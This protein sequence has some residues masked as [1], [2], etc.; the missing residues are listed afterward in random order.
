MCP[1][2]FSPVAGNRISL[3]GQTAGLFS[4]IIVTITSNRRGGPLFDFR[5]HIAL[6]RAMFTSLPR[7]SIVNFRNLLISFVHR[8]GTATILH[9][10]QTVSSFRCR[11]RLTGV[12]HRL[13][14][15]F[16]TMFLAPSRGCSFVSSA[17]V[18][19]V[20]GLNNSIAG[21]IPR[22]I[23]RNFTRGLGLG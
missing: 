9:N 23:S 18:H 15:G 14:R 6:I 5:R 13:S 21:F 22:Y 1:N 20:T 16:R 7:M 4:R 3:I 12:G 10:L 11:F 2:A 19:R 8:G 17:V